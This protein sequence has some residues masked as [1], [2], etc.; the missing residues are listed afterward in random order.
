MYA[1]LGIGQLYVLLPVFYLLR[2]SVRERVGTT[3][4]LPRSFSG[5][6]IASALVWA[7][8]NSLLRPSRSQRQSPLHS[9]GRCWKMQSCREVPRVKL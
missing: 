3:D 9:I 2:L 4:G 1:V 5:Q 7:V 8:R 6:I